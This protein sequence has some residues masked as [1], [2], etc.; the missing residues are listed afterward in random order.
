MTNA[1]SSSKQKAEQKTVIEMVTY[2][3]KEGTSIEQLTA[4]HEG[5]KEF[6]SAQEGFMYRSL[7]EDQNGL[8]HDIVYWQNMQMAQVAGEAFMEHE[9]GQALVALTDQG[10]ITM[11]H[12]EAIAEV[13]NCLEPA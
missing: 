5:V 11:H 7:S 13:S 10:S 4:T 6:L 3:L 8:L 1:A 12:M 9:A 2:K